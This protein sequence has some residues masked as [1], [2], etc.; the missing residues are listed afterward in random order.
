MTELITITPYTRFNGCYSQLSL[1]V[2]FHKRLRGNLHVS[3]VRPIPTR[4]R[5]PLASHVASPPVA[6]FLSVIEKIET[7]SI[8]NEVDSLP[9]ASVQ[10]RQ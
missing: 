5:R 7:L 4:G 6:F 10:E 9:P 1:S 8:E 2:L 3:K